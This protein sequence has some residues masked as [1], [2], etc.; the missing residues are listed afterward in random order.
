[1]KY[2]IDIDDLERQ[3]V[4]KPDVAAT[5]RDRAG[6]SVVSSAINVV[7]GFGAIAV[8]AGVIALFPSGWL[9]TA[10]GAGFVAAACAVMGRASGSWG[11]LAGIWMVVGALTL[12]VSVGILIDRP[13][14]SAAAA[15]TILSAAAVLSR[16]H[17]LTALAPLALAAVIGAS[18]G[19]W[20]ACY[21]VAVR[22]PAVTIALFALLALAGWQAARVL[23]PPACDL[24]LTLARMSVILVNVG[25]WVG[26]LCGDSPGQLWRG[27]EPAG[28]LD[29]Q[30]PAVAFAAA[31][32]VALV[33]A[34][35]WGARSGRRFM[36][37]AAA[38]FGAINFYSQ[39]FERLGA[40]PLT[41]LGGGLV[42]IAVGSALLRY[43]A[44]GRAD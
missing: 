21:E 1:M 43:N 20:D 28:R 2:L 27:P 41:V 9:A 36:V 16:S 30:I 42:A 17:L 34:G 29:P 13:L 25:F 31:W 22:E 11:Q 8:A 33:V 44:H 6:E 3:G 7:L 39:W 15:A 4:L 19:Y 32:A 5:L 23:P 12:S 40:N 10:I 35:W 26:S 14:W 24:A 18:A 37:N 38:T